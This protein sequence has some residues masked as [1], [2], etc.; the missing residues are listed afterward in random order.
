MKSD[1][2]KKLVSILQNESEW[3][4]GTK[5]SQLIHVDKKTIRNYIQEL[6]NKKQYIIVSTHLITPRKFQVL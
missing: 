4:S 6:N 5:L 1:N 2:I 3:I